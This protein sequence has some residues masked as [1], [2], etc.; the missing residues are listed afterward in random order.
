[1]IYT[2]TLNPALDKTVT[3]PSFA[4]GTVNR[5][6]SVR[7]DPGGKG[8]NGSKVIQKLGGV[9]TAMGILA[10]GTG[11]RILEAVREM[12]IETDFV[13]QEGESRTNLKIVDPVHRA[14]TEINEPGFSYS[15]EASSAL[16]EKL[17][18][19]I[20]TGDLVILAGRAPKDA[21]K[22]LCRNWT[23]ACGEKGAKVILDADGIQLA[24]GVQASPWLIKP[25][26]QELAELMG[27]EL[28]GR[29]ELEEAARELMRQFSIPNVVVSLGEK[30]ALYVTAGE[31]IYAEGL[32][33]PVKSTVGAGDSVVAALAVAE[34]K[35]MSLEE[36]ARFST[37]VGAAN[38]MTDGTSAAE[39]GTV[40]RLLPRVVL[41]ICVGL[42]SYWRS[43]RPPS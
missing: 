4:A 5:V 7:T 8:I 26:E 33:V 28:P 18:G 27:R 41:H 24:E 12:G 19:R 15:E 22:D 32:S 2:V 37:A 30:G 14:G 40:Q 1:M 29:D 38:V 11:R 43:V 20:R 31:T 34:E 35:G 21:P 9:S 36:T 23:A 10:G 42:S 25:N 17:L 6:T 3:I 39:Y 16:L 13:F